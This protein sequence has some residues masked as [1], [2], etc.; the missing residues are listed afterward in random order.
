MILSEEQVV[1]NKNNN[2]VSL[3]ETIWTND[4]LT[5]YLIPVE[6]KTWP[7]GN[8]YRVLYENMVGNRLV[9]WLNEIGGMIYD[10]VFA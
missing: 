10:R 1:K 9:I 7:N 2:K 8:P 5:W 6:T 4:G 3:Y